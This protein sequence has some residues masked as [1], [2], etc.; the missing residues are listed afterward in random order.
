MDLYIWCMKCVI[1]NDIVFHDVAAWLETWVAGDLVVVLGYHAATCSIE[2]VRRDNPGKKIAVYQLEQL[3]DG[4]PVINGK[5]G[6][7]LRGADE[8]WDFDLGNISYLKKCGYSPKYVP[9]SFS[10]EL[11]APMRP[12]DERDIDMLFIGTPTTYRLEM[13][14]KMM[15]RTQFAYSTVLATGIHGAMLDELVSRCKIYVNIHATPDYRC[16]E[17]VRLFRPVSGGCCVVSE[18]SRFNEFGKAI[19]ECGFHDIGPTCI[20]LLHTGDWRGISEGAADAYRVHC[21]TRQA[22][23]KPV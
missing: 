1:F 7:W 10:T 23:M 13:L 15:M 21:E 14:Q 8:I 6:E 20:Q 22:G 5:C 4:A 9:L 3:Y 11:A 18:R 16:Q 2:D 12:F 19:I 17:Q